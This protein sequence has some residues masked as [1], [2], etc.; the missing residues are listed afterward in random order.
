VIDARVS[1][2]NL[3]IEVTGG[4]A[5][6]LALRPRWSVRVPLQYITGARADEPR[7]VGLKR[8]VNEVASER[9]H[10][11]GDLVCARLRAPTLRI[12]ADGGPYRRIILSVSDPEAA[13]E[14][15]RDAAPG[16]VR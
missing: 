7:E 5:W 10:R 4:D 2:D 6:A 16:R 12:D 8:H 13:A 11:K 9:L 3:E 1:G 14:Q 15:I